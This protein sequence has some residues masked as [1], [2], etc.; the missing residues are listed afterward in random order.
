MNRVERILNIRDIDGRNIRFINFEGKEI[1]PFNPRGKRNF[2]IDILD[3]AFAEELSAE[4][5]NIRYDKNEQRIA[6]GNT[7]PPNLK[8]EVSYND[9]VPHPRIMLEQAGNKVWLDENSVGTLDDLEIIRIV[10]MEVRPYNWE[11]RGETGV[12][13]YLSKMRIE[14]AR[15]MFCD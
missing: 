9:K 12:T 3:P 14:A 11:V 15:D 2:C 5:W 13:A 1:P 10:E 6:E 8:I 7:Y 4:G